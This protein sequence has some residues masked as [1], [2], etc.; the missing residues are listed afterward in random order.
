MTAL[1]GGG[2]DTL[3]FAVFDD[4][5]SVLV[6]PDD[7]VACGPW[8]WKGSFVARFPS[9]PSL[10][11]PA[12]GATSGVAEEGVVAETGVPSDTVA[13]G[14]VAAGGGAADCGECSFD[15]VWYAK[16][17]ASSRSGESASSSFFCFA[18]LARA[19]SCA[20]FD[21]IV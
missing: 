21:A 19:A 4:A 7:P 6:L 10:P 9:P 17:N 15:I 5:P 18:A 3:V 20:V 8:S 1:A 13:A 14:V 12:G 2:M 16:K 11:V